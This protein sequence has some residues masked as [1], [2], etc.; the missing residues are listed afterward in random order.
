MPSGPSHRR[1]WIVFAVSAALS[2]LL[3]PITAIFAA[4]IGVLGLC[5]ALVIG[6]A[7]TVPATAFAGVAAGALPYIAAGLLI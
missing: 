4:L 6:R 5:V 3:S 7:M 2:L 1:R